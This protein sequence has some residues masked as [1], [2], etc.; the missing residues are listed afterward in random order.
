MTK[1]QKVLKVFRF[2]QG[3]KYVPAVRIAGDYLEK[4][5]FNPNDNVIITVETNRITIKKAE[6]K[7]LLQFLCKKNTNL[8]TFVDVLGLDVV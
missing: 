1:I 4:F 8:N 3:K 6:N 2:P 7:D 5:N